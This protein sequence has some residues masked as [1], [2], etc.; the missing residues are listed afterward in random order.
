MCLVCVC[1][2][3]YSF[4]TCFA[5]Q[6]NRFLLLGLHL[7]LFPLFCS[8]DSAA[9]QI[10]LEICL[11]IEE[12]KRLS[13]SSYR[14]LKT[15]P[16]TAG[17]SPCKKQLNKEEEE[18]EKE[19]DSLLCSLREVQCLICCLL[20]QMFIADP[21]IAKLVHFQVGVLYSPTA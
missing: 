21:N 18:E 1:V 11:P 3:V 2:F 9:V 19:E 5:L 7:S 13:G 4:P 8:Q 20:H 10:L 6:A 15:L 12:E 17:S 16:G 14:R